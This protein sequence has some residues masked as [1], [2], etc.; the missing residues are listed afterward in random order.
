[1]QEE[2]F[3]VVNDRDEVINQLPRS[4]VHREELKHR[5]VHVLVFH[6]DGRL[7]LQKRSMSKDSEPGKWD[8]SAAGHLDSGES[9]DEAAQR[10]L[11]GA[12]VSGLGGGDDAQARRADR[13]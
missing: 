13:R 7:F 3:D 11:L 6:N 5:A 9:Y 4:Q 2:I 8:S 12:V 10:E 1:M